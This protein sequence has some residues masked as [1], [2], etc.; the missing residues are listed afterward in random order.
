MQLNESN[1][2]SIGRVIGGVLMCAGLIGFMPILLAAT[3]IGSPL[4]ALFYLGQKVADTTN[5]TKKQ[6]S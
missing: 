1:T 5:N 4:I 3:I 6:D 2:T